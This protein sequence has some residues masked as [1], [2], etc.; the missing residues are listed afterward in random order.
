MLD[1]VIKRR[2]IRKYKEEEIP[3]HMVEEVLRAGLLA[4]SSKKCGNVPYYRKCGNYRIRMALCGGL[5][6]LGL[7]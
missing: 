6:R 3:V 4:P 5:Q 1:A 2:S 7:V